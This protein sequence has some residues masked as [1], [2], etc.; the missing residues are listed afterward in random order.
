[1]WVEWDGAPVRGLPRA[2]AARWRGYVGFSTGSPK[3]PGRL[4]VRRARF[5]AIPY[6]SRV[7]SASPSEREIRALLADAPRLA[8][9]SPPGLVQDGARLVRRPVDVQLLAMLTARG[10]WDLVPTVELKG[11][12][13]SADTARAAEIA[14]VAVRQGWAGVRLVVRDATPAA[15]TAWEGAAVAWRRLFEHRGLRLVLEPEPR[16]ER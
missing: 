2:V 5:A 14:D 9:V 1:V 13:A 6:A 8:A 7:V 3:D 4:L 16:S 12:A 11:E 15:R 10:A